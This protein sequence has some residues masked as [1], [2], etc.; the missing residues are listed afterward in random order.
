[1]AIFG[2]RLRI[3]DTAL[4]ILGIGALL[5]LIA[6]GRARSFGA[7]LAG[8]GL[9]FAGIAY[10]QTGMEGV[11]GTSRLSQVPARHGSSPGSGSW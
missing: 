6:I 2:F 7:V 10:M 5:W 1:V 8:F 11:R 4:P 3:A 9:L